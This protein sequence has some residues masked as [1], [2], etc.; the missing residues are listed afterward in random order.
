MRRIHLNDYRPSSIKPKPA[1]KRRI[2]VAKSTIGN[3]RWQ[4]LCRLDEEWQRARAA[5]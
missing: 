2:H 5:A 4:A 1:K 3:E